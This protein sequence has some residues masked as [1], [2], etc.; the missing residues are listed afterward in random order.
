MTADYSLKTVQAR[1]TLKYWEKKDFDAT[2]FLTQWK[3]LSKMSVEQKLFQALKI[4]KNY[5]PEDL[6]YKKS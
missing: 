2:F 6:L 1:T 5:L 4:W 3:Y